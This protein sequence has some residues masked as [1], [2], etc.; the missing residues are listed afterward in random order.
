MELFHK[1]TFVGLEQQVSCLPTYVPHLQ[2]YFVV[3]E[4]EEMIT[5]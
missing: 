3:R 4:N 1:N 2:L 5:C